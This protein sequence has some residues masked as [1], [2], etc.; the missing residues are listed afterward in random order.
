MGLRWRGLLGGE[1]RSKIR[2]WA[3]WEKLF[4]GICKALD[5]D[6]RGEDVVWCGVV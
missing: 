1:G 6:G 3:F 2:D 5:W 4:L